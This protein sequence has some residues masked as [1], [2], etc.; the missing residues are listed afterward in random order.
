MLLI[1]RSH[2]HLD[3]LCHL[4]V[5]FSMGLSNLLQIFGF[6][7]SVITIFRAEGL[8]HIDWEINSVVTLIHSGVVSEFLCPEA[9]IEL[10]DRSQVQASLVL[11]GAGQIVERLLVNSFFKIVFE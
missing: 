7:P 2:L 3:Q 9:D 5:D 1:G 6:R 10:S 4:S 8:R 11:A